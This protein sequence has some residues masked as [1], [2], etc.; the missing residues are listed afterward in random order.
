[1]LICH[2]YNKDGIFVGEVTFALDSLLSGF[3]LDKL[4]PE[5]ECVEIVKVIRHD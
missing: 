4:P 1:M 5:F 3:T 2:V